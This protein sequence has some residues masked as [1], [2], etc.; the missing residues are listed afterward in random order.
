MM[1]QSYSLQKIAQ[2]LVAQAIKS[3]ITVSG[4]ESCTGGLIA[5]AITDVAG[6]SAAFCGACVTY[7]NEAKKNLLGVSE[8]VI[9]AHTE[10]SYACAEAMA[11][12]ARRV[13]G[14]DI[15]YSTTGYAGPGGGTEQ[16]PVGTVYIAICTA[17]G[18]VSH[19][20]SLPP[21]ATR[22]EVRQ[23]AA[24]VVLAELTELL[25]SNTEIS[26]ESK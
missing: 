8:E 21:V 23:E 11:E 5:K 16:D 6:S 10:V 15:A 17:R 9:E 18:T 22:I 25:S 13:F 20:L 7:T 12:G 26:H 2:E 14:T 19:R 1:D 24:R 3:S 4:A